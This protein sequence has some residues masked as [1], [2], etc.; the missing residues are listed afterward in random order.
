MNGIIQYP[1]RYGNIQKISD[2][3]QYTKYDW[4]EN[5]EKLE[6][7]RA[8]GRNARQKKKI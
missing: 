8:R 4:R 2:R 3:L 5:E 1:D 7:K 6:K